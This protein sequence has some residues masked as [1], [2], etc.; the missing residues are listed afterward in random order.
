MVSATTNITTN[1]FTLNKK[2]ILLSSS[3]SKKLSEHELNTKLTEIFNKI[4][5][6]DIAQQVRNPRTIRFL[7]R[8]S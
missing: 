8:V 6:L 7:I 2:K 1:T 5:K 4:G 3:S